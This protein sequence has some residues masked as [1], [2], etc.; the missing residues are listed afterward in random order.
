LGITE[1]VVARNGVLLNMKGKQLLPLMLLGL[2][3]I[4]TKAFAHA[5]QTNYILGNNQLETQTVYSN[6]Q[7]L[8]RAKVTVYAPNDPTR[9]WLQGVTDEQ[10]R[11]T[12]SPDQRIPGN[13]EITIRQEGHDDMLTVPV[14]NTGIQENLISQGPSSD[15]HYSATPNSATPGS[16]TPLAL[17]GSGVVTVAAF[18]TTSVLLKKRTP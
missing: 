3:S 1:T 12:F 4:P 2:L 5:V 18:G 10:G 17:I 14:T 16:T 9:P 15:V 8:K 11:F 6:G 13:W 7:P